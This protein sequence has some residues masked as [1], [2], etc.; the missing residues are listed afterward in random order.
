[1]RRRRNRRRSCWFATGRVRRCDGIAL[2]YFEAILDRVEVRDVALILGADVFD[3]FTLED[4]SYLSYLPWLLIHDRIFD[5]DFKLEVAEI[6][7][8]VTLDDVE[9]IRCRMSGEVEPG[10]AIE[11]H[12]IDEQFV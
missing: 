7:A 11:A 6:R 1:M 8:R 12:R 3:Q 2:L 9:L 5:R 10:L 4:R